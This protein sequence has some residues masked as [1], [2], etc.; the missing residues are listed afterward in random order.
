MGD[1]EENASEITDGQNGFAI[2]DEV[3]KK[4]FYII[5]L[6]FAG[7]LLIVFGKKGIHGIF[8]L[9]RYRRANK[10]DK[11]ILC[12]QRIVQKKKKDKEFQKLY[13]Y[14]TQLEYLI[15]CKEKKNPDLA[16]SLRLDKTRVVSILQEAGFSNHLISDESYDF[17]VEYLKKCQ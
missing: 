13:C 11:L 15:S 5:G 12:Y 17:A 16:D 7:F 8:F 4:S 14:E 2:S 6:L 10:N 1:G 9:I 3:V